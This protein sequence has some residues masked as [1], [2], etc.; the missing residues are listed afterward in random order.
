MLPKDLASRVT[1][2]RFEQMVSVEEGLNPRDQ[3]QSL[4][5][6]MRRQKGVE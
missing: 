2:A 1:G 5:S 4:P 3:R 6:W